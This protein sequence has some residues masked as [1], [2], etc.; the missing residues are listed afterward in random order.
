MKFKMAEKSLFA[1]LLR[2]PWWISLLVAAVFALASKAVLPPEYVAIGALG[3]F[4]FLVIA[5]VAA[6]RQSRAP[7]PALQA[8]ALERAGAMSWREFSAALT[9]S[10]GRQGY[11]VGRLDGH[12][13]DFRLERNGQVSLVSCRR[14][15]AASHG[16]AA[17]R[18]LDAL[19]QA[20]GAQHAVH[21]SL[22]PLTDTARRH[23]KDTGI[24]LIH[25]HDLSQ[26]LAADKRPG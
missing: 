12:A 14:W 4:P 8:A 23:A 9:Q 5:V 20:Q 18:E 24:H 10:W 6:W 13:A 21:I 22:G 17:L 25:G 7:D 2:S 16:V 1:I 15:K 11:S 3:G 26:L 19:R